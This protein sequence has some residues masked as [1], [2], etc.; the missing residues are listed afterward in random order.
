MIEYIVM[1]WVLAQ[2]VIPAFFFGLTVLFL[3]GVG[4]HRLLWWLS[5]RYIPRRRA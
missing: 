5:D 2:V 3:I 4:L 1:F